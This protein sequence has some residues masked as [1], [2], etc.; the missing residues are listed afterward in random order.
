MNWYSIDFCAYEDK[1]YVGNWAS[2]YWTLKNFTYKFSKGDKTHL[3]IRIAS[4]YT[5]TV[6][7][8]GSNLCTQRQGTSQWRDK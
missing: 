1:T 7:I 5:H 8:K 3:K 4:E 2:K 6:D